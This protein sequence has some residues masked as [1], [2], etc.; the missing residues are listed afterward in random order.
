MSS[1]R[2]TTDEVAALLEVTGERVRWQA[3]T[4]AI[5]AQK[6]GRD[7]EFQLADVLDYITHRRGP[8]RPKREVEQNP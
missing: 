6:F 4:G 1:E 2:M 5:K 7:W 3:R 8:G